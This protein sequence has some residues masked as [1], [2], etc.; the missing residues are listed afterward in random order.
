[1]PLPDSI[2]RRLLIVLPREFRR[3]AERELLDTFADARARA[4]SR[5][6]VARLMFWPRLCADLVVNLP[7]QH[8]QQR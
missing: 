5:G 1:M 7:R 3:E 2:Y 4:R 8:P 6:L